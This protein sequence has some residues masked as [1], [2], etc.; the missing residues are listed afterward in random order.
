V[1]FEPTC[2]EGQ[3]GLSP[4][5]IPFR[6]PGIDPNSQVT[7]S[8]DSHFTGSCGFG[9]RKKRGELEAV[10]GAL[11]EPVEE[12]LNAALVGEF[13]VVNEKGRP[14]THPM[15]P[16]YDG[17]RIYLHSSVLFSKK[18]EHIKSN[19]RVTLAVTDLT[20]THGEPM[21]NRVTIQGDAVVVDRDP[22]QDWE[23]I[24]P[25]WIKKEPVVEKFFK[26]R[27]ALPLFWERGLIE[28]VPRK[29]LFWEGG[30]TQKAPKVYELAGTV[31]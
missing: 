17:E 13:T 26:M 22:H 1:G 25:L 11:P 29:V 2:P 19:P 31:R 27:V 21:K 10:V 12:V 18:L 8:I 3:G 9:Y 24:L 7:A 20:A 23:R 14:I 16:I 5:R 28:V 15:I 6:H 4:Q 30:D